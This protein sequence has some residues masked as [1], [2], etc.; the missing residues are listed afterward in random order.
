MI[1]IKLRGIPK[2]DYSLYIELLDRRQIKPN[3]QPAVLVQNGYEHIY[4]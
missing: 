4:H 2:W 3:F 1:M